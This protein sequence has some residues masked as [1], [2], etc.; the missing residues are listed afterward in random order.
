M[1]TFPFAD[2]RPWLF[3]HR[4]SSIDH[5]ENT[6]EAFA[7]ALA[8]GAQVLEM[9]LHATADGEIVVLHDARVDRTTDGKGP[10]AAMTWAALQAL[11]AGAQFQGQDGRAWAGRGLRVPRF[12]AVLAAFPGVALNVE[13]KAPGLAA[14]VLAQLDA[15]AEG[16]T[17]R[18]PLLLAA[19]AEPIAAELTAAEGQ[20]PRPNLSLGLS[21]GGV[22]R[23]LQRGYLAAASGDHLALPAAL[24][25]RAFQAPAHLSLAG[26]RLRLPVL[27]RTLVAALHRAQIRVDAFVVND[28]VAAQRLL[29]LGVDGIMTDDP[30]GLRR[31]GVAP[32]N[33]VD[34]GLHP[35]L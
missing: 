1:H 15:D 21:Q 35:M 25:G 13:L 4:G 20:A 29:D 2:L 12:A 3:A 26:G 9:D 33:S 30:A 22:W 16:Q 14:R 5:P 18:R 27:T 23:A 31:A 6:L 10:V 7:A 32:R 19:A 24:R 11:D 17:P 28:P 34:Q 8:A